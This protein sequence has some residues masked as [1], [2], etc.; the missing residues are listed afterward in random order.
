MILNRSLSE[1][2]LKAFASGNPVTGLN[3]VDYDCFQSPEP[4][5]DWEAVSD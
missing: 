2:S 1:R 3:H 4:Y 5:P